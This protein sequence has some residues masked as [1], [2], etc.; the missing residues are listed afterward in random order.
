M[1][2]NILE[3]TKGPP[4]TQYARQRALALLNVALNAANPHLLVEKTIKVTR[5][6]IQ[7]ADNEIG[8]NDFDGIYVIGA[9]KA[10]GRM[11]E[12]IERLLKDRLVGGLIIVP[13]NTITAYTLNQISLQAGGH[14]EPTE[15]SVA[16]TQQLLELIDQSPQDALIISLFSGGG[17]ALLTA[18]SPPLTLEDL[19]HT[20][21]LLLQAGVPIHQ[22]NTVRKHLSLVKG[23]RLATNIHPRRHWGLLIS[24]VPDDQLNMIASGPTLPDPTTFADAVQ[25]LETH[26][27]WEEVPVRVREHLING[28][29]GKLKETPK[30]QDPIFDYAVHLL[31]GSNQHSCQAVLEQ[32]QH[33]NYTSRILTTN[34]EGE[35]REVGDQLGALAKKLTNQTEPHVLI[36]GSETT[37]TVRHKGKGGRNTELIAAAIPHLEGKDGLV[38]A[39]L[40]TDGIDGPT[41]AA[42]AIA[43]G[44]SHPRAKTLKLSPV[45]L[46]EINSTYTLFHALE[47]LIITGPTHTN[48][49]DITIIL[50]IGSD[51]LL[52]DNG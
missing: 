24:D 23:G 44:Y 31:I 4:L 28:R 32:A 18:P 10:T 13:E 33:E 30:P 37:V 21:R 43:D 1:I 8:F 29:E 39:S 36:I 11:A 14:P 38:I 16:S 45:Q 3:L 49:R 25:I 48:V 9:G 47:D 6:T 15:S 52:S 34:C 40:A 26:A 19:Q 17:S 42:G 20:T 51:N 22:L 41:K 35:A 50:W 7:L 27:L 5:S 46:L 2:R 12:A